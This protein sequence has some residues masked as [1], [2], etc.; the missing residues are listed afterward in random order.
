MNKLEGLRERIVGNIRGYGFHSGLDY[1][2]EAT[3]GDIYNLTNQIL[4][5]I[6]TPSELKELENG[7]DVAVTAVD[8]TPPLAYIPEIERIE[9]RPLW[10][11]GTKSSKE[12]L[13]DMLKSNFKR[14]I[15]KE[16]EL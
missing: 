4:S 5:L 13:Q 14:F 2:E 9:G 12:M 10:F 8:Q 1:A 15:P 16:E 3:S 11:L 6:F 7:G